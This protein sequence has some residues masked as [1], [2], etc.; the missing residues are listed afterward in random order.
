M[1]MGRRDRL[2]KIAIVG[3]CLPGASPS[4]EPRL[5]RAHQPL[6]RSY[7]EPG[8]LFAFYLLENKGAPNCVGQEHKILSYQTFLL[9]EGSI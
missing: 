5:E 3:A 4:S 6:G 1:A 7:G 9:C 2:P 8:G